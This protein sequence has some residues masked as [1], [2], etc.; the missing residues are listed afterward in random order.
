[1]II[2]RKICFFVGSN[3]P[4]RRKPFPQFDLGPIEKSIG[5]HIEIF[6]CVF[7]AIFVIFAFVDFR[8]RIKGTNDN[9][10]PPKFLKMVNA[11]LLIGN[12]ENGSNRELKSL[13]TIFLFLS[14]HEDKN[15][16]TSYLCIITFRKP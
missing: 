10:A 12:A 9:S 15:K 3:D 2:D 5:L 13:L 11:T 4:N 1:M 8:R 16:I 7:T 14:H 6:S